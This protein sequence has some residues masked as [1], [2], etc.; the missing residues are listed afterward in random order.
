MHVRHN[1]VIYGQRLT[2]KSFLNNHLISRIQSYCGLQLFT[3]R[4]KNSRFYD[5]L[6]LGWSYISVLSFQN[7]FAGPTFSIFCINLRHLSPLWW[8]IR[9]EQI[10]NDVW[11]FA[12]RLERLQKQTKPPWASIWRKAKNWLLLIAPLL[13]A[14]NQTTFNHVLVLITVNS[15]P[16]KKAFLKSLWTLS[17]SRQRS[18][19]WIAPRWSGAPCKLGVA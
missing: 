16:L 12:M 19:S 3:F 11:F 4:S 6:E 9:I 10:N 17:D 15:C 13:A 5:L 1:L 18:G 7:N 2:F 8:A 14:I